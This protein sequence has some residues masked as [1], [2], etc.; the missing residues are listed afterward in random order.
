MI[1]A[2]AELPVKMLLQ[3]KGDDSVVAPESPMAA[4]VVRIPS[5]HKRVGLWLALN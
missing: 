5:F 1:S 2:L 4:F 3:D